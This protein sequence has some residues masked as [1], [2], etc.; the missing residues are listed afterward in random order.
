LN[1]LEATPLELSVF[2]F[3]KCVAH[4]LGSE[5]DPLEFNVEVKAATQRLYGDYRLIKNT[6]EYKRAEKH[7]KYFK[8][9]GLG[10]ELY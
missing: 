1:I 7:V 9:T 2:L 8:S 4:L 5:K 10:R 3:K 6:N